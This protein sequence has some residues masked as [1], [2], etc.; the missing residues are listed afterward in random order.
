MAD[1]MFSKIGVLEKALDAS[2]KR[3]EVIANNIANID[4]P[5]FKGSHVVFEAFLDTALNERGIVGKR[6]RAAHLPLGNMPP[7]QIHHEVRVNSNT[8]MRMDG[9]NVDIDAEMVAL[10]RNNLHYNTLV[11]KL[12]KE[13]GRIKMAVQEGRR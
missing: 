13:L 3:N 2:W 11:Q 9:N 1:W 4:T 8:S 12:S 10:A 6:T 5:G 7:S